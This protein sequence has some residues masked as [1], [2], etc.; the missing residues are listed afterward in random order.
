MNKDK[1]I[2]DVIKPS[3]KNDGSYTERMGYVRPDGSRYVDTVRVSSKG[4]QS[5]STKEVTP[6]THR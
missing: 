3:N 6:K 1:L 4:K 2:S 5:F